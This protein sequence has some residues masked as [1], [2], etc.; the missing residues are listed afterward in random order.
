MK[1][2]FAGL[3]ASLLSLPGI[4]IMISGLGT[5]PGRSVLFGG[6]ME[7]AGVL[8]LALLLLNRKR[9]KQKSPGSITWLAAGCFLFFLFSLYAYWAQHEYC[10]VT[11]TKQ[12]YAEYGPVYYPLITNGQIEKDI[13]THGSR[14]AVVDRYGP[15]AVA[16]D[17]NKM[18]GIER[19]RL[20][21]DF[22]LSISY[23]LVFSFLA[24]T[25][26]LIG[27]YLEKKKS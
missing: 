24:G 9:I 20:T 17:L 7:A 6:I 2:L 26:G 22:I 11:S 15:R 10:L 12:N 25:F 5:P 1:T 8:I 4:A 16:E 21:T 14:R 3:T 27:I 19:A 23:Q 18:P 13:E